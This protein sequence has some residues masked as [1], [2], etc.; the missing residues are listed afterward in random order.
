MD[1][2]SAIVILGLGAITANSFVTQNKEQEITKRSF[3]VLLII[4]AVIGLA[5]GMVTGGDNLPVNLLSALTGSVGIASLIW[6]D[7]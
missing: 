5:Y 2:I 3:A 4:F 7:E 1:P 6:K